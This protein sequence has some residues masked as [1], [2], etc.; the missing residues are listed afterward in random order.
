LI[1]NGDREARNRLVMANLRLVVAIARDFRGRGLEWDDLISE[2]NLGLI[3]AAEKFDPKFELRFGVY[4]AYWI[5]ANIRFALI[6]TAHTIRI[7]AHMF[8]LLVRWRRAES[9]LCRHWGR[10]P[11]LEDVTSVLDVS[12]DQKSMLAR[13][14]AA[15]QLKRRQSQIGES[16]PQSLDEVLD[17]ES[18]REDA[19]DSDDERVIALR[20]MER[21]AAR[22][23]AVVTM[24]YGMERERL[25]L[26][27][28]GRRLGLTPEGV[29]QIELRAIRKLRYADGCSHSVIER[30]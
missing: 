16:G 23:R 28:V 24:R 5:K 25:T 27:E 17:R 1:A 21:L 8:S 19:V 10:A 26:H 4:A 18:S 3:R 14:H 12:P 20:R 29:R 9:M 6:N 30:G 15:Y 22:E 13:A 2:G 11:K 7:P